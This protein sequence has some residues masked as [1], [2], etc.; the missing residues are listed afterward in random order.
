MKADREY[1][2]SVAVRQADWLRWLL[3]GLQRHLICQ[4]S[5]CMQGVSLECDITLGLRGL[6]Q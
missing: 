6:V 3:A 2:P 5:A 4:K 1:A